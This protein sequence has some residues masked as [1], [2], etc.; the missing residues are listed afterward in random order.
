MATEPTLALQGAILAALNA[1]SDVTDLVSDRIYDRIPKVPTFPYIRLGQ[2]QDIDDGTDCT[3]ASEIFATIDAFSRGVGKPEVKR[4][5]GAVRRAL[6]DA[7]LSL[8]DNAL[9]LIKYEDTIYRTDPDGL[10]EHAIIRFKALTES[11]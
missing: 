4:I 3:D 7:D 1:D 9:V 8:T 5:A 10:T 11:V 2:D 6:H